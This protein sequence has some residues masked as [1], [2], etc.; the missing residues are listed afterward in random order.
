VRFLLNYIA[1]K[2]IFFPCYAKYPSL[3]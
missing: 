2:V 1:T 3:I